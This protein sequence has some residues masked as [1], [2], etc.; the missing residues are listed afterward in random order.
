MKKPLIY[1]ASVVALVASAGT[2]AFVSSFA[3]TEQ[4]S[5]SSFLDSS[6]DLA[7][8]TNTKSFKKS[9][10]VYAI[11]DPDGSVNKSFIDNTLNTSSESL[12]LEESISYYL[13]GDEISAEDLVGKSGRVKIVYHF[14]STKT[15][16]NKLVPFLTITSLSFDSA[17][18]KNI[19]I[20][21]GKV[22]SESDT[23]LLA[24]Y[25]LAGL[26]QDLNTDLVPDSF[27]VTADVTDFEMADTYTFAT[28]E[29]FGEIDTSKLSSID[30][31]VNSING[32]SSAFDKILDGSSELAKG[33]NELSS[34]VEKISNN[35]GKLVDG[36]AQLANGVDLLDT[37]VNEFL[38]KLQQLAGGLGELSANSS[39]LNTNV[40]GTFDKLLGDIQKVAASIQ[41]EDPA[42]AAVLNNIV[43][44]YG[45]GLPD[46][47]T[48][49]G[50]YT[51]TVDAMAESTAA[52]D[53]TELI[54]GVTA[55]KNGANGLADGTLQLADGVDKL[56]SGASKIANGADALNSGL[57]AFKQQGLNKLVDFANKDITAFTANLRATINTAKSYHYYSNSDADSVKFIFKTPSIK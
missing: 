6:N 20:D 39:A 22:I 47:Y 12:P 4:K 44:S 7:D 19:K 24:G 55:L 1:A 11:T 8:N 2:T 23:T 53:T 13:D 57:A 52:L 21:H 31:V 17:K 36:A 49:L 9:E 50:K 28:N 25:T 41:S 45:A 10:S 40:K 42:T 38:P 51:G 54:N 32:L 48:S 18:F 3:T 30:N 27:T 15:Y 37:K 34:G 26:G 33:G 14:A 35:V 56:A 29:L 5:E 46:L 43:S 16:Q